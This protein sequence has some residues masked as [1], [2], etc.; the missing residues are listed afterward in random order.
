M[1]FEGS[2]CSPRRILLGL[3]NAEDGDSDLSKRR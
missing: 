2:Y 3:L 1:G